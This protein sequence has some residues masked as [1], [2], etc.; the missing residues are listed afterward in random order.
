[1]AYAT[2]SA[3]APKSGTG[4]LKSV[5]I[6]LTDNGGYVVREHRESTGKSKNGAY[7]YSEPAEYAFG[8][9]KQ[10]KAYLADCLGGKE[11]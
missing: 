10:L 1:M 11:K 7:A 3:S 5:N 4:K 6:S 9:H 8:D 2:A